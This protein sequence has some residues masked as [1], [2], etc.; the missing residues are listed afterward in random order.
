MSEEVKQ[1]VDHLD[2]PEVNM[3]AR[4]F[5][6]LTSELK[7]KISNMSLRSLRRAFIAVQEFPFNKTQPEL[8]KKDEND[9]FL[10][11]LA[12][13]ENKKVMLEAVQKDEELKQKLEQ[14]ANEIKK[15]GVTT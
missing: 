4:N 14:T 5:M 10:L 8:L 6:G 3:A 1:E 15:E 12:M 9:L 13:G 7:V 2:T 11:C